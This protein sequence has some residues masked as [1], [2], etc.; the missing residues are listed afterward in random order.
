M[1]RAVFAL[2]A[3]LTLAACAEDV[4]TMKWSKPG[5]TYEQ[6]VADRA[7]CVE[8]SRAASKTYY[9][10]GVRYSGKPNVLDSGI[11]LPCMHDHGYTAGP[12]GFAAPPG[13][14]IPLGP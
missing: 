4:P 5:A 3:A 1:C 12:N 2:G 11:F 6:F 9:I 14:E 13:D 7:A 8:Q 10:G